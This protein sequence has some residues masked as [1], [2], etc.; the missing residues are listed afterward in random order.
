MIFKKLKPILYTRE[1]KATID[2]Y[3]NNLGFTVNGGNETDWVSLEKDQAEIMFSLPNAHLPFEKAVC[4]GSFYITVDDADEMR[5]ALNST[6]K[7]MYETENFEYG[8][9]EFAIYDNNEYIVQF[10]QYIDEA[11]N[12]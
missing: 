6:V 2:F 5:R 11:K 10:G 1:L 7:I 8:M 4:T 9:R 12:T 3:T